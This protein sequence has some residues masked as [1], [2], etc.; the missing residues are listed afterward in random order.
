MAGCRGG[1]DGAAAAWADKLN[2]AGIHRLWQML[3]KGL[4]DVAEAPDPQEA[5]VMA[6]LRLIHAADLPD[7]AALAAK[8]SGSGAPAPTAAA[9]SAPAVP[10]GPSA[11]SSYRELIDRLNGSGKRILAQ[12]LHDSVSQALYGIAGK[13]TAVNSPRNRAANSLARMTSVPNGRW[14]PCHSTAP[15]GSTANSARWATSAQRPPRS[16]E[17]GISSAIRPLRFPCSRA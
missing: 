15:T 11:P 6:L 5:V 8:L 2:W 17:N 9:P 3:L 1:I 12:E 4:N 10:S 16:S 14:G 13:R 7:P